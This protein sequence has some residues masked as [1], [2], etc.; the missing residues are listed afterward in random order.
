MSIKISFS[1]LIFLSVVGCATKT[2]G[3]IP[4][5]ENTYIIS[6][7]EGALPTGNKPLLSD[8][9][10]EGNQFCSNQG[11]SFKLI[12]THENPGPYIWGNYPKATVTF[13]CVDKKAK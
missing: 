2:T 6:K 4:A 3:P 1:F 11:K 8:S 5:G 9:L 12:K 7:Q 10:T 13:E